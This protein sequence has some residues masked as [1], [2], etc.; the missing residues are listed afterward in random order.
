MISSTLLEISIFLGSVILTASIDTLP[1]SMLN[2]N[3]SPLCIFNYSN[4]S[5]RKVTTLLEPIFLLC[6]AILPL[7]IEKYYANIKSCLLYTSDAADE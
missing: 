4:I 1:F 3:F 6:V 2:V 5:L 7:K